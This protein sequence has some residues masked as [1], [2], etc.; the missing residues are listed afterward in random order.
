MEYQLL[1][2]VIHALAGL[3]HS[4]NS[5]HHACGR[6]SDKAE[7]ANALAFLVSVRGRSFLAATTMMFFK[8]AC[9]TLWPC[10]D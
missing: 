8:S 3:P 5:A 1:S 9:F 10:S 4:Y 2:M 6:E 7:T